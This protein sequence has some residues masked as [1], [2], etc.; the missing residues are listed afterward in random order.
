MQALLTS[1]GNSQVRNLYALSA[2]LVAGMKEQNEKNSQRI[3]EC[4]QQLG[5]YTRMS[6]AAANKRRQTLQ[7]VKASSQEEAEPEAGQGMNGEDLEFNETLREVNYGQR[8]YQLP[9]GLVQE[10]GFYL[11]V[12]FVFLV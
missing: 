1:R 11:L 10:L 4:Y 9:V 2:K 5:K 8:K 3:A 6:A 12:C 7:P